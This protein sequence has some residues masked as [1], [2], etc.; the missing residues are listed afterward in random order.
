MSIR[1]TNQKHAGS[2]C[3]DGAKP[4]D[5][6]GGDQQELM[7]E[8]MREWMDERA[9]MCQLHQQL[10]VATSDMTCA[11]RFSC[12][13][14]RQLPLFDRYTTPFYGRKGRCRREQTLR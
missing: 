12:G 6:D 14:E 2:R 1:S 7:D 9:S 8:L 4:G 5:E 10:V 3:S 11:C 13:R